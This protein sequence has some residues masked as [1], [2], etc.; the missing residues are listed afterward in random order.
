MDNEDVVNGI[1]DDFVDYMKKYPDDSILNHINK[2]LLVE[3]IKEK[4]G[5]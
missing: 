3:K 5:K 2:P 4:L 1:V